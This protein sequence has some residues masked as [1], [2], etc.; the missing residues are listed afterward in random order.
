MNKRLVWNFEINQA[1]QLLL[2]PALPTTSAQTLWEMRFFWIDKD[3]ITLMGLSD[4]HLELS[5]YQSKHRSDHYQL[6]PHLF[7]NLKVRR[8]QLFYKPLLT[9]T[10]QAF[11]YGKKIN[12]DQVSP[13]TMLPGA[14]K[15]TVAA[16]LKMIQQ[17]ARTILLEKEALIYRFP[18]S[19]LTK[20]ELARLQVNQQIYFSVNLESASL[21]LI[22]IIAA[23]LLPQ[24]ISCDYMTFLHQ[25]IFG[26]VRDIP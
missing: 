6:L 9:R 11:E 23:Q 18:T 19:P 13:S 22:E 16:L 14:T 26:K 12:L 2:P 20:L 25:V 8:N 24:A 17:Q 5:R 7:Y 21:K 1:T 4:Q 10:S 3:P 15:M